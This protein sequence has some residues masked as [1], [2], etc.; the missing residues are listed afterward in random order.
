MLTLQ[1][2]LKRDAIHETTK[3]IDLY[4]LGKIKKSD[5]TNEG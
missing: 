1:D 4:S 2:M 5:R 3:F